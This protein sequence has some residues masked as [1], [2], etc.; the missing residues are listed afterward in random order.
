M[1]A[2]RRRR[3]RSARRRRLARI[4]V[5]LVSLAML[6]LGVSYGRALTYPGS[7]SFSVR[8]VEWVREHGGAPVVDAIENWWYSRQAPSAAGPPQDSISA[9]GAARRP[10][11]AT[12]PLPAGVQLPRVRLLGGVSP[13]RGEGAWRPIGADGVLQ[14]TWLR[15]DRSHLPV[16]AAAVLIP[17]K[18]FALHLSQGTREPVV[19]ASA[20]AGTQVPTSALDRLAATFNSGFKMKDSNGGFRLGGRTLV[21]LRRGRASI[22]VTTDGGWRLGEWGTSVGPSPDVAAVRQNLDLIVLAGRPVPGV[23]KNANGRWGTAHT[24]FQYT[25]RSGLGVTSSGDLVYIAG[26]SMTLGVLAEAMSRLGVVT[27][28]QLD[29]HPQMVT[30]NIVTSRSAA[31]PTMAKLVDSMMPSARR[32]LSPDQ[33]DFFFVTRR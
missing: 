25:S 14:A 4:A 7:A 18:S 21:P 23:A 33:R 31:S 8:S 13:L 32:Y 30:F 2:A 22:V 19:G 28:M 26:R 9:V 27:G 1:I 29:I 12:P 10:I 24:Q 11:G 20:P 17:A 16:V 6:P 5:V 15:P 3:G